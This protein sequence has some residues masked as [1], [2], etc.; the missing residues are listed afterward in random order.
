MKLNYFGYGDLKCY[1][2]LITDYDN[3]GVGFDLIFK[4]Y[5]VDSRAS[6]STLS[7]LLMVSHKSWLN[8][9]IMDAL[10]SLLY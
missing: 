2:V 10:I 5:R 3:L 7:L 8:D 9:M 4:I 1:I 6:L